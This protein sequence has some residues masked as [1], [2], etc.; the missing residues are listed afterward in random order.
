M[1]TLNKAGLANLKYDMNIKENVK[2]NYEDVNNIKDRKRWCRIQAQEALKNLKDGYRV[3]ASNLIISRLYDMPEYKEA[4]TVLAYASMNREVITLPLVADMLQ[5]GKRV[6]LP[7]SI[8]A[9]LNDN[10]KRTENTLEAREF[11]S[12]YKLVNGNYGISEPGTDAP[13]VNPEDIDLVILPCVSCDRDC[14]R[15]GHGKGYY[16]SYIKK[17]RPDCF[18]VAFCFEEVL[19]E[20]IPCETHDE[21]VDA[22]ITELMLYRK[23]QK[24]KRIRKK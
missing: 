1:F 5:Q 20:Q 21:P 22:V 17:L 4:K 6:C 8:P 9:K 18:K 19:C 14:R 16:D 7:R 10:S 24:C 2:V 3:E 23:E 13:L 12:D 15:I 11:K